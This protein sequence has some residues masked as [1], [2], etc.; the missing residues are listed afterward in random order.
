LREFRLDDAGKFERGQEIN[1]TTFAV[2]EYVD[3]SGTS[4]GHGFAGAIKRYGF[5][6]G[7]MTHGSKYHRHQGSLASRDAARIFKGRKMPGHYGDVHRTVQNLAVVRVD[8][9]RN[10]MLVRGSVPG[11]KGSLVLIRDSVKA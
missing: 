11:S 8:P 6:R 1:V 5:H 7:P 2:G 4:R 3:V 10:L 9:A